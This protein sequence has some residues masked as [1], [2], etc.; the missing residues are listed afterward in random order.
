MLEFDADGSGA[1]L[2]S[3]RERVPIPGLLTA[4]RHVEMGYNEALVIW[5]ALPVAEQQ[6]LE[7]EAWEDACLGEQEAS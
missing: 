4:A 2:Q 3:I 7:A 6:R 5:Y 1:L